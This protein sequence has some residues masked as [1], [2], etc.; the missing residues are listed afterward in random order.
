MELT[1]RDLLIELP[2]GNINVMVEVPGSS[3]LAALEN[4]V[5][6][7]EGKAG[8]FPQVSGMSFSYDISR[9]PGHR[10]QDV[11]IQGVPL[12]LNK[13]YKVATVDY[14]LNGGDGYGMFKSG[15]LLLSPLKKIDLVSTVASYV[16]QFPIIESHLS[17]RIQVKDT[18]ARL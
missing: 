15:K 3:L 13:C 12:D 14:L 8:R 17:G 4:G 5:S 9:L 18:K 7:V 1:L 2:F 11:L 10:I 16:K 6:Q